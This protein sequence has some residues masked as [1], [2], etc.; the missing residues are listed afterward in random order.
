MVDGL[1][2]DGRV[3][4]I[5][6]P[7]LHFLELVGEDVVHECWNLEGIVALAV[8]FIS[9]QFIQSSPNVKHKLRDELLTTFADLILHIDQKLPKNVINTCRIGLILMRLIFL[10]MLLPIILHPLQKCQILLGQFP[11]LLII[12][13]LFLGKRE[14]FIQIPLQLLH[15]VT[16]FNLLH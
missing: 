15:I 2:D 5:Q 10:L 16:V 6:V 7:F 1:A 14:E 12:I 3:A 9:L 8:L 4:E 11:P 13:L